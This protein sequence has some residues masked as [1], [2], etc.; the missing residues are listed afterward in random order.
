MHNNR[1]NELPSRRTL[2]KSAIIGGAA[3]TVTGSTAS[4]DLL[5]N[6]EDE[7]KTDRECIMEAGLTEAEAECW[8][9]TAEAAG[10]FFQLPELHPEDAKEVAVAVHVIQHKLLARPTY[11]KYLEI[12]KA[13]QELKK[14][15]K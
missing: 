3:A 14:D 4:N 8:A 9:K 13:N 7:F 1:T 12:A 10:A 15:K 11:R 6:I 2:F 5:A